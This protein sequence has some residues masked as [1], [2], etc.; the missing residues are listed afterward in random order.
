MPAVDEVIE[1]ATA[2]LEIRYV[3]A[4]KPVLPDAPRKTEG[5]AER[6]AVEQEKRL[7]ALGEPVVV[8][9]IHGQTEASAMRR[10]IPGRKP[11][12]GDEWIE[13]ADVQ[14][15]RFLG[16]GRCQDNQSGKQGRV[17][18]SERRSR[19]TRPWEIFCRS[20]GLMRGWGAQIG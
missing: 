20:G 9:Q 11:E 13:I 5:C 4:E 14:R 1:N 10:R 8:G 6:L 12:D 17:R 7:A 15:I 3:R 2:D 16:V 18:A 19:S